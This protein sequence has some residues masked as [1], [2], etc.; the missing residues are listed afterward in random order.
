VPA[1]PNVGDAPPPDNIR[2]FTELCWA[3]AHLWAEGTWTWIG[4][5]VDPLQA[6]AQQHGLAAQIG[7]DEVQRIV[8]EAF[9]R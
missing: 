7:Q 5:A 3:R 8:A 1:P 2:I 6:W 4:D 9:Q